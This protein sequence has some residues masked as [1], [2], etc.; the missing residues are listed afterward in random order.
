MVYRCGVLTCLLIYSNQDKDDVFTK[1]TFTV[2]NVQNSF[3]SFTLFFHFF[4]Q[5]DTF[6]NNGIH[7]KYHH[8]I[9]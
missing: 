7:F 9:K 1:N 8:K 6:G 2:K 5:H 3:V 4:L